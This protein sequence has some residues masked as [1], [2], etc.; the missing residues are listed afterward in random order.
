MA[1]KIKARFIIQIAGKPKE[2]VEN[3]FKI[4][5]EKLKA[6]KK[7]F[8]V[9]ECEV[10][11]L[12]YEEKT[13]LYTGFV[14]VLAEFK[15]ILD[16][17]NFMLDYT[18][19]S[20]EVESPRVHKIENIDLT[21]VLNSLSHIILRGQQEIRELRTYVHALHEKFNIKPEPPQK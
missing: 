18:P 3:A 9:V 15:T 2:A 14:D 5:Q 13:T 7:R 16:I 12:E 10:A 6:E 21:E 8:K 20:I 4:T 1:D 17:M 11:E 19:S